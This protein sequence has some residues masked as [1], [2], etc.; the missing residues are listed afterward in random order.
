MMMI[1]SIGFADTH[2]DEVLC[3]AASRTSPEPRTILPKIKITHA[4]YYYLLIII[5]CLIFKITSYLYNTISFNIY[6]MIHQSLK[7]V[8]LIP[9]KK[10]PSH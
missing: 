4:D 6:N 10:I 5:T 8:N 3:A 9:I 7:I 2:D 1:I